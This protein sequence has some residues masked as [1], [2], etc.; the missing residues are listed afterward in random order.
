MSETELNMQGAKKKKQ[1]SEK[2][3][4]LLEKIITTILMVIFI[5]VIIINTI[6]IVQVYTT[7]EHIPNALGVSPVVVMSGSM[8]P[9]FDAGSLI[10]IKDQ[11]EDTL[12]VGD[13]ICYLTSGMAVTHRIIEVVDTDGVQ[14]YRVQ[15]DANNVADDGLVSFEHIEGV[16]F[17]QIPRLGEFAIFMQSLTGMLLFI[18]LPLALYIIWDMYT[19]HKDNMLEKN[20]T[21]ELLEEIARLKEAAVEPKEDGEIEED[22][23]ADET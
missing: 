8:S 6:L 22:S 3:V 18:V 7:P 9:T 2:N 21:A 4:S 16:Y 13:V 17:A 12:E 19:S 11:A 1:R 5:P 23:E 15:G 10:F 20:R 14:Q